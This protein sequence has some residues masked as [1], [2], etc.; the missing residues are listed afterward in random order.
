M[1]KFKFENWIFDNENLTLTQGEVIEILEPLHARILFCLLEENSKVVTREVLIT[2]AWQRNYVDE[3]TINAAISKL[4]K[5]LN[6]D[7][8]KYIET[9]RGIGYKFI[10]PAKAVNEKQLFS[11]DKKQYKFV[12]LSLLGLATLSL[13][14]A[15]KS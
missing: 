4:R 7:T 1:A 12:G 14:L 5:L 9:V 13:A 2:K 15:F 10:V 3:R 11:L 8:T 6:S